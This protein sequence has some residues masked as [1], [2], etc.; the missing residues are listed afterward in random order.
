M[1]QVLKE[2]QPPELLRRVELQACQSDKAE[3][4]KVDEDLDVR[5]VTRSLLAR[6]PKE[7]TIIKSSFACDLS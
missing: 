5:I 1:Q 2:V 6:D 7:R 4:S 3:K